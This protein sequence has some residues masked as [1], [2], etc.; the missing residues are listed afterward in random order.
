MPAVALSTLGTDFESMHAFGQEL[1][2]ILDDRG[3]TCN[4]CAEKA[5]LVKQVRESYHLPL[6]KVETEAT[7]GKLLVFVGLGWNRRQRGCPESVYSTGIH[8]QNRLRKDVE[9]RKHH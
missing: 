3:V 9:K 1:Q 5:D 8:G 6:K 4:G 7:A 2:K